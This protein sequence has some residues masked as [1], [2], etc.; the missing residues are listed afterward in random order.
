[1]K[2]SMVFAR[3]Y[4]SFNFDHYR[5][6]HPSA[7][8]Q[9]WEMVGDEWYPYVEVSV[10]DRITTIVGANESGKSHLLGAIEKAISGEGFQHQD[11]CRYCAFFN[12][13]RGNDFWPHLGVAWSDVTGPEQGSIRRIVADAPDQFDS[14]QMF[15]EGPQVLDL[16]FPDGRGGF[17]HSRLE[18]QSAAT[19][20]RDFLPKPFRIHAGVGLPGA[21]PVRH[22][23]PASGSVGGTRAERRSLLAIGERLV[24]ALKPGS[25]DPAQMI[26][27][28][29]S[30]FGP[31]IAR[32][33]AG[34]RSQDESLG[35][36]YE[37]ARRLLVQL[38][39][40]E[41]E[42]LRELSRFLAD[43]EDGHAAA[44]AD[45]INAQLERRLNFPRYWVQDKDFQLLVT[46]HEGELVFTIRDRTGTQYTFDERSHGLK[47]FL[48]YFIQSKTHEPDPIRQEILLMDEPDAFLSAEAQQDL[49]KIF[50]GF[51]EPDDGARPVQ[52]V[53]VTHSPFLLDKNH[54]ERIRV[55]RKG[56]GSDGTRVIR[57]AAQN[58]Y[59]PLR[60]AIGAYVGETAFIGS[61]NLLVEGVADQ[62]IL[63]GMSR[64]IQKDAGVPDGE[65]LDLNRL[66]L[67]PCGSASQVPYMIYLVRGRDSEVPPVVVLLDSDEAGNRA[68]AVLRTDP[69]MSRLVASEYVVQLGALEVVPDAAHP[70]REIE[71]LV[72][73]GLATAAARRY[74]EQVGRSR[75]AP[76][77]ESDAVPG[78]LDVRTGV[79]DA[80]T[81]AAG[82]VGAHVDKI[83]FA[84]AVVELCNNAPQELS[85]DVDLF[86]RRMRTLFS[87]LNQRRRKAEQ[88]RQ[89]EQAG[90][91]V[92]QQQRIFLRDHPDGSSREQ[93]L[94]LFERID[95]G[96]DASLASE[97]IR[98]EMLA[99]R[100][101]FQFDSDVTEPIPDFPKFRSRLATL[102][103]ALSIDRDDDG[104]AKRAEALPLPE[105]E[106]RRETG[107]SKPKPVGSGAIASQPRRGRAQRSKAS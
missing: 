29:I 58:H 26:Q 41:P 50:A 37:L 96:L 36:S 84:R 7:V 38:G 105:A 83:G 100:H 46:P 80:V 47:Y 30:D 2:L 27:K 31:A 42:R 55:L 74:F 43:G 4:K 8:P 64:F 1:M 93:A 51:A 53:Y 20:G 71:D 75:Q 16:Y 61:S 40:V 14:F 101:A 107:R 5:K 48:S 39:G 72:P 94:F 10:H 3:F 87:R 70:I 82:A 6:A 44:L 23:S 81:K 45:S 52:V 106:L 102:K 56:K 15:R 98:T 63:A 104:R 77:I 49:L 88:E 99:M 67:V 76:T 21:L 22:L 62:V 11:L 66:V 59:E 97:A 13:E 17:V 32:H 28:L 19:F 34:S 24:E 54:A 68:A 90:A 69:M 85:E 89:R 95:E 91:K 86:K 60:S 79:F 33:H 9:P 25:E 57:N 103:D 78:Y 18:G 73:F 12:V 35:R 65:V 92:N